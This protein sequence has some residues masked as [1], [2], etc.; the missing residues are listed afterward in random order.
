MRNLAPI[1]LFTYNRLN[2]TKKTIYALQNNFLASQSD[3]FIFS[4]GPKNKNTLKQINYVRKFLK[5]IDGFKTVKIFENKKNKGLAKSII[6]G[7]TKVLSEYDKVIVLEDDLVT[8][9]NFLDFMNKSL[10]FYENYK[11]I[12]SINGYSINIGQPA[13]KFSTFSIMRTYSW[14]WAT[15]KD[16]WNKNIFNNKII[17]E[18][19]KA[20][21]LK[22]FDKKCG[23]DMSKMLLNSLA[24]KNDSWYAKWVFN[25]YTEDK[26]AIYPFLSKIINIGY[27]SSATHCTTIDVLE[28][29]FD[30]KNIRVFNFD[31]TVEV[32]KSNN[33]KFLRFFT[34][35][36]KFVYRLKLIFKKGG[37][38]LLILDIKTKFF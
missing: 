9:K 1:C 28:S 10:D 29:K 19:I 34:F 33:K 3:L 16:C 24:G 31:K 5:S 22:D 18:K 12:K 6:E 21:N 36:H 26:Y 38:K 37:I 15:W 7:V 8:S 35:K 11:E 20:I 30:I 23:A 13:S 25:H 4:D 17:K 27:G 14:G 2:E 32:N